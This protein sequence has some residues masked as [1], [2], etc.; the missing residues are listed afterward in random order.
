[1]V[2]KK[3][4]VAKKAP[5]KK[6]AVAKKKPVAKKKA[7][8]RRPAPAKKAVVKVE[9]ENKEKHPAMQGA[10]AFFSRPANQARFCDLLSTGTGKAGACKVM[11][12]TPQTYQSYVRRDPEFALAVSQALEDSAEP[13]LS[14]MRSQA[15]EGDTASARI[16]LDHTIKKDAAEV[17]HLHMITVDPELM[18]DIGTLEQILLARTSAGAIEDAEVLELT[19]G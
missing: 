13:V 17:N 6:K 14:K 5:V 15:I 4:P 12:I 7:A 10:I 16:F 8:P 18:N 11:K 19:E 1:M 9:T 2:A 3:K